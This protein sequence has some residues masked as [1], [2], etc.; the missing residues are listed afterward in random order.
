MTQ[1]GNQNYKNQEDAE[2]Y[3]IHR[4]ARHSFTNSN[5]CWGKRDSVISRVVFSELK[6]QILEVIIYACVMQ[7]P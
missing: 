2:N 3:K 4:F 7:L 1:E 6:M 5:I